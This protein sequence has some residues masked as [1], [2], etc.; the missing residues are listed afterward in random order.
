MID[1][2]GNIVQLVIWKVPASVE[3]PEGIPYR[4]A[5]VKRGESDPSVLYDNHHPK[6]HHRSASASMR[7]LPIE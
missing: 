5:F 1:E 6:G 4:L 3:Y 7:L 2:R